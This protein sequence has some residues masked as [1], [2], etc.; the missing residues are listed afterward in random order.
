MTGVG[1]QDILA[2]GWLFYFIVLVAVFIKEAWD[3]FPVFRDVFK[4]L[5]RQDVFIASLVMAAGFVLMARHTFHMD[6][7]P[8]GWSFLEDALA[9]KDKLLLKFPARFDLAAATHIPAYPLFISLPLMA[10]ESLTA[11]SSFNLAVSVLSI[12]L[13]YLAAHVLTADRIACVAAA[14]LLAVSTQ[15]IVYSGYE[16]PMPL[17]V[18]FVSLEFLFLVCFLKTK[19]RPLGLG[20]LSLVF[21]TINIKPE[22]IVFLSVI[23]FAVARD[24]QSDKELRHML[25]GFVLPAVAWS[26]ATLVFCSAYLLNWW[27]IQA[28]CVGGV[29]Y[30]R[31]M[32]FSAVYFIKNFGLF[33]SRTGGMALWAVAGLLLIQSLQKTGRAMNL[34]VG[35]LLAALVPLGYYAH[36]NAEWQ[37]MQVLIP[38]YLV[39]GYV[40]SQALEL[41]VRRGV[42]LALVFSFLFLLGLRAEIHLAPLKAFSWKDIQKDFPACSAQ[43]CIVSLK[44]STSKTAL[45]FL[46]PQ[47]RWLFINAAGFDD[48]LKDCRAAIYYFNPVVYGL[49]E[50][51]D[52]E[53]LLDAQAGLSGRFEVGRRV[54]SLEVFEIFPRRR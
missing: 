39:M 53:A 4:G 17:S 47:H 50:E 25:K 18:F 14:G 26:A 1:A 29:Y 42:K 41:F 5:R 16:F 6:L 11:V 43:D 21:I 32:P 15:H 28:A 24:A 12:G 48:S 52:R 51:T 31:D 35:W 9:I 27:K 23:L 30:G 34:A 8:Y 2:Y 46:F 37:L 10:A 7:D 38:L 40:V 33:L 45:E 49:L 44:T 22:N 54:G 3:S 36:A 20:L 19:K 13:V